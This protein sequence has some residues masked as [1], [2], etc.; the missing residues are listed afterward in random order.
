MRPSTGSTKPGR[1]AIPRGLIEVM[2]EHLLGYLLDAL[3][4]D[5]RRRVE[6][7]LGRDPDLQRELELL[8]EG[9]DPLRAIDE[10]IEPPAGLAER[11]C[12]MLASY[13]SG[14]LAGGAGPV[15]EAS[16][17]IGRPCAGAATAEARSGACRV[18]VADL[19]VAAGVVIAAGLLFFPAIQHSR[20]AARRDACMH[21]LMEIHLALAEYAM[22]NGG[23]FPAIGPG[24]TAGIYAVRL[25]EGG[26]IGGDGW[27][28]CPSGPVPG[29]EPA[30]G[31]GLA[32]GREA[33]WHDAAA[34]IPTLKQLQ[35]AEGAELAR[36][37]RSMGGS[38]GAPLHFYKGGR[39]CCTK[40]LRRPNFPLMSD[41]PPAI[42]ARVDRS[43]HGGCARNV[44]Y[45]DGHVRFQ[46]TCQAEGRR[47][48]FFENDLGFVAAGCHAGDAVIGR[49][50]DRPD[51]ALTRAA[52]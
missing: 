44:L 34:H 18:A 25:Q 3:D 15:K 40:D 20:Q 23:Y 9:L 37:V 35:Q 30:P 22:R 6:E 45:E 38:Y 42:L 32:P 41:M 24:E 4:P 48:N 46:T 51:I 1:P 43:S 26:Y 31:R 11:T 12:A 47:D 21:K 17:A 36:W 29:G 33:W 52:R 7:E 28:L 13:R 16:R 39:Y 49:S 2:R 19:V 27:N 10:P 14:E 5:E 50:E 8:D